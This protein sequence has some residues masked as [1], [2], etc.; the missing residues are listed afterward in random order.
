MNLLQN[1][2]FEITFLK[3]GLV[4]ATALGERAK[5]ESQKNVPYSFTY[6]LWYDALDTEKK[7]LN[8]VWA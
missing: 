5:V 1:V 4:K 2:H 3:H 6:W 8:M 7:I